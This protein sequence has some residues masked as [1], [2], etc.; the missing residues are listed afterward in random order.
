[1]SIAGHFSPE[2]FLFSLQ[3]LWVPY[4]WQIIPLR[5]LLW[6]LIF[7]SINSRASIAR[8]VW[9]LSMGRPLL[10]LGQIIESR[11]TR[12]ISVYQLPVFSGGNSIRILIQF[13][14]E[15]RNLCRFYH[16]C[17]S[18]V[19]FILRNFAVLYKNVELVRVPLYT[20]LVEGVSWNQNS[21]H[22]TLNYS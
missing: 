5:I 18:F 1:M 22:L 14:L 15:L 3:L 20:L 8:F 7:W 4:R 2:S 19:M 6:A 13:Q 21:L 12:N 10:C 9:I 11:Q 16:F 17:L